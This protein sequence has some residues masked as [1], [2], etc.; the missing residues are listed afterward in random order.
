M[1]RT[2]TAVLILLSCFTAG[3]AHAQSAV[4]RA[5]LASELTEAVR[6][7]DWPILEDLSLIHI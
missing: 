1:H 3:L 7:G 2:S 4:T 5:R 6:Q